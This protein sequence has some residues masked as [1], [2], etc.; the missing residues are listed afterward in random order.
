VLRAGREGA[1]DFF[2]SLGFEPSTLAMQRG[3]GQ[4]SDPQNGSPILPTD[5]DRWAATS[6]PPTSVSIRVAE[7]FPEPEFSELQRTVFEGIQQYSSPLADLLERERKE[8]PLASPAPSS[9][10][11]PTLRLG[12][13]CGDELVGW[14]FGWLE[15]D[16]A[17]YMA[18]SGVKASWRRQGIYSRLVQAACEHAR[19]LGA[20]L[21][22]SQHSVLNNPVIVAKLKSG[23]HLSGLSHSAQMG[24]LAELSCYLSEDRLALL[25]SRTMPW[26]AVTGGAER[27]PG[28]QSCH[29]K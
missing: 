13:Y 1:A 28:P 26:T 18:N 5:A 22:R 10:F 23:F 11:S 2:A 6:A 19:A 17:F 20:T 14:S 9:A 3:R 12:A 27:K 24:A 25:R 7:R 16:R 4:R 15:R 29:R 21:V 8:L